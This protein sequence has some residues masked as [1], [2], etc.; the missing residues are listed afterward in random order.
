M[1]RD[2]P[3]SWPDCAPLCDA[4]GAEGGLG[5]NSAAAAEALSSLAFRWPWRD[6]QA[7]VLASVELHMADDRLHIVAAPGSGKT[8]LGLEV[9]RRLGLPALVLSPTRTIRNQWVERLRDFSPPGAPWPLAWSSTDLDHP[10]LFTSVTYQALHRRY[11]EQGLAEESPESEFDDELDEAP[12]RDELDALVNHLRQ[13]GIGTLILDEAHHL[14][15]EWWKALSALRG[16]LPGLKLVSLTATPPYDVCG[17]EWNKYHELC[18]SIDE[19]IS[20]P[21]L[22]KSGTLCPHQDYVW[23]V[24]PLRSEQQRAYEY[25]YAVNRVCHELFADEGFATVVSQHRWFAAT[26]DLVTA[27]DEPETAMALLVFAKVKRMPP[28]RQLLKALSVKPE[29]V[30]PIGR[31][32]WQ[33][34][35]SAYLFDKEW[36]LDE[37][38]EAQRKALARRLRAE[39]LLWRNTL[40]LEESHLIKGVLTRSSA[41]IQACLDIHTLERRRRKAAL[42]QVILTDYIRD[43]GLGDAVPSRPQPLGAWPIFRA[44]VDGRKGEVQGDMALLTGRLVVLHEERLAALRALP[45]TP[46]FTTTPLTALPGFILLTTSGSLVNAITRLLQQGELRVVVGTR[47][48]LGEG[49]DAPVVNSL[50]LASFVGSYMLTN[51]MRGRAIRSD[52]EAPEK[53]AT[54]WHI[55]ALATQTETGLADLHELQRRFDTF[56]GLSEREAVIENGLQRMDLPYL[57]GERVEVTAFNAKQGNHAMASRLHHLDGLAGRWHTAI[58]NGHEGRVVPTIK[59]QRPPRRTPLHFRNTMKYLLL[60]LLF[61]FIGIFAYIFNS[62]AGQGGPVKELQELLLVVVLAAAAAAL[63]TLP[64]LIRAL[65]ILARH[66][67]VD[68]TIRQMGLALRD[69]LCATGLIEN[70]PHRLPVQTTSHTDGSVTISLG[71]GNFYEQSLFADALDE[72]LAP[73]ENPRYLLTR[74]KQRW[75]W[76]LRDYHAVPTVLGSKK[77]YAEAFYHAWQRRVGEGELIYARG[78]EGRALLLQARARAFS[79]AMTD[80]VKRLDR[81]Q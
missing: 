4:Q 31:R 59:A 68:G 5:V 13:A 80:R 14:R 9:F 32:W 76:Q 61:T 58:D 48:L 12:S 41:K 26:A 65:A 38:G 55:V 25:D 81:W 73:I 36:Q 10:G 47:A 72:I 44:L 70:D 27:L 56:V 63:Y 53:V 20:V 54:I 29:E 19:E 21:E 11:R 75:R 79:T 6:Y 17:H 69:A 33:V 74:Q 66:L 46:P 49:W 64:K 2:G 35:V 50:V 24:V 78:S 62:A 34:L 57:D 67:P 42:R 23:S 40:R 3:M 1:W 60:E 52:Q 28:P 8:T 30:P 51:Q 77:E 7:R 71:N 15:V 18:G 39:Q 22:V 16:A 43:E 45:D 37:P